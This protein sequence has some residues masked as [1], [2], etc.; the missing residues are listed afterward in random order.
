MIQASTAGV[1]FTHNPLS[2]STA[3]SAT[4]TK[5]KSKRK[6][7]R[8]MVINAARGVCCVCVFSYAILLLIHCSQDWVK[9]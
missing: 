6:E 7:E 3:T 4:T 1:L 5:Q 2:S 8:E 9:V